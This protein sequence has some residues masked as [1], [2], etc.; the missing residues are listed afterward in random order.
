MTNLSVLTLNLGLLAWRPFGLRGVS[1]DRH[2]DER[3]AAA[4]THLRSIGADIIA[5][6]EVYS[7]RDSDYL[8]TSLIESHPFAF[9][10]R[11]VRSLLGS[12]LMF[13]SRYPIVH[14]ES[15]MQNGAFGLHHTISEK[16]CLSIEVNVSGYGAVRLLN[17]HLSAESS[18]RSSQRSR[19][20]KERFS[21]IEHIL[22]VACG[23]DRAHILLGD[24]N[25]SPEVNPE[26]YQRILAAGLIDA[27][28]RLAKPGE[29]ESSVTWDSSNPMNAAGR[30]RNSPSQRI[31]HVFVST[32]LAE[33]IIPIASRIEFS[34]PTISTGTARKVPLSDHYGL[35]VRFALRA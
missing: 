19:Q 8:R 7:S 10:P 4:P 21:D 25:S 18:E 12:G 31:D 17:V 11:R 6:Q 13:L 9:V 20:T 14:A 3:L 22:A 15:I 35:S 27:F 32:A 1:I 30:Y 28:A 26:F 34:E 24:F 5:L 33:R 16:A 29:A 2:I 23:K